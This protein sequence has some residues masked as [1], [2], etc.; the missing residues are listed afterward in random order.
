[1][2]TPAACSLEL[3]LLD[4]PERAATKSL[5]SADVASVR[6]DSSNNVRRDLVFDE[7]DAVPQRELA[8]FQPLQPEQIRRRRLVQRINRRVQVAVFLLQAGEFSLQF[9]LVLVG[10]DL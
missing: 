5:R 4:D 1:M 2:E 9:A 3:S 10:H 6:G 8:F 7:R